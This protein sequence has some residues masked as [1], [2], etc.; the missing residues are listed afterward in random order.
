MLLSYLAP[1]ET[2]ASNEY[3]AHSS[4]VLSL[5]VTPHAPFQ[6]CRKLS[7]GYDA[8]VVTC[9]RSSVQAEGRESMVSPSPLWGTPMPTTA[10]FS[11]SGF[12]CGIKHLTVAQRSCA[13]S[14][15]FRLPQF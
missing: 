9:L 15:T 11:G 14:L 4:V 2:L 10:Q 8:A 12:V 5:G 6:L 7:S 3:L 13:S 1:G